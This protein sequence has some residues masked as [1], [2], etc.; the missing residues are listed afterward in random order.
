MEIILLQKV[1]NVGGIGDLRSREVRLRS[2]LPDPAGQGD[3][4]HGREQGQVR[5]APRG[6]RGESRRGA[7]GRAGARQEARGLG[8]QD[9]DAG[10][11]R[12]QAVR[13]GRH[14][15]HR[16][17]DRQARHRGRA[18]RD[19]AARRAAAPRRRAPGRAAPA[20]RRQRRD[21]GRDRGR[22][23]R[24]TPKQRRSGA[25][26]RAGWPKPQQPSSPAGLPNASGCR[27]TRSKPSSRC[28]AA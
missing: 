8:A 20:H 15:R 5:V 2:E 27:R 4:G 26:E 13:L 3:A 28:S 23:S 17:R 10:R 21:H 22:G 14:R 19:S 7:R 18:Q 24:R 9:R 12:R 25:P 11:R 16:R 6:A 1:D